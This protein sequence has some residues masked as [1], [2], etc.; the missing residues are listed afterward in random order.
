MATQQE[1]LQELKE[2]FVGAIMKGDWESARH[3]AD[4]DFELREPAA[5]PYGGIY[6]GI[7]GFQQ[8]LAAIQKAHK[9]TGLDIMDSYFPA[10]GDRMITEMEWRGIPLG[11]G[12]EAASRVLEHYE[13]RD[14]KVLSIT[15]FWF[16]I[17]A[18]S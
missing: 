16:N 17:P 6:K 15:L 8:C 4:P 12:Q 7:E 10:K 18:Y 13:F 2:R 11:T 14:G 9:T 1:A 3:L 5:L